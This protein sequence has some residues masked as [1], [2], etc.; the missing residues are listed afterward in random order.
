[1]RKEKFGAGDEIRTRDINLGKV[2][3]YQL[4]Y[5]RSAHK[6][7]GLTRSAGCQP[8][9]ASCDMRSILVFG[10]L[11]SQIFAQ[12]AR[13]DADFAVRVKE[14]TT[15]PEFLSPLVD[16]L[17]L[18]VGVPSPKDVLGYHVGTPKKLATSAQMLAY[19]RALEKSSP[20]VKILYVG[21]T[22]EGRDCWTVAIADEATIRRLDDYKAMLAKL[23]D[24][25][26][27]NPGELD[28]LLGDAKPIYHVTGGLHSS[29]T[30]P[31]DMLM[32][33]GYRI[34]AEDGALYDSIRKNLIVFLTPVLEPD[35]RDRYVAWYNQFKIHEENEDDRLPGPPYWGKYI[36]HDNNRDMHYSQIT[37]RNWLAAYLEWHPPIIHDLHESVPFL[38]TFSGQPPHNPNLDP[39]LYAELPWFANFEMTKMIGYGMPGV[40]THA[41][42]DMW[43]AGYLGFMSSNH[44]GM[45]RMYEVYGNGGA[46]TMKRKVDSADGTDRFGAS[47]RQWYRPLPAYKEVEWSFRNNINYGQTGVLT[48]LELAAGNARTILDNFYK[49]SLHSIEA[50]KNEAP[51]AFVI[52]DNQR[53]MTRVAWL[54]NTLRLQ[55]IEI[56]RSEAD[57]SFV[58]KRDQPYG[59]LAKSLLE[60]QV[61]PDPNLRTY[62]D[63]G[64]TMGLLSQVEVKAS[65]DKAILTAKTTPVDRFL[66]KG[67][68]TGAGTLLAVHHNGAH[69]LATLRYRLGKTVKV[70]ALE[71]AH[72]GIPAGSLLLEATARA[73]AL[74]EELGLR[75]TLLATR[76]TV[77]VH[78]VDLPRLAMYST[79]GNTQE[80]GW[81]RHAFDQVEI[82]FDLIFKD[83]V[84][85][86]SLRRDFDVILIPNQGRTAKGLVFDLESKGRPLPYQ[87]GYGE[88][89]DI[90]GGMG[91]EGALE[92]QKFVKE[93]GLLITL[94]G[95]SNFPVEYGI[96]GQV[97][98]VR[99]TA[100]FYAPG[101]IVEVDILQPKHP[102]F[103]GYATP[104]LAVRYANGP[105]LNVP[106]KDR[107]QQ[108]LMQF[109]GT[110]ASV[111]SGFMRGSS[112]IRN[113]PA[114]VSVPSGLG[115]VLMFA[116]NPCYRWQ[117]HGEFALLFNAI[118]H[119]NDW[120]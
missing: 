118:Q 43:S 7:Y 36:Y 114:L 14:W 67:Q 101:P 72:L 23:A 120:K 26:R 109:S 86:G 69:G 58:I 92:L 48:A 81:V 46:N 34:V 90:T 55:G 110:E 37:M 111:L 28:A 117:N 88:S 27:V 32:E 57:N 18:V 66:P 17:P 9:Y 80:V 99:P 119:F 87:G 83:R 12:P 79:W 102:I 93:G 100:Q 41:F 116:T 44:N 63:T 42:V 104:K 47:G 84:R 94:A 13:R 105:L 30:G 56:G 51:Y 3:L 106:E 61:Y 75:A 6:E 85:R 76:P 60:K 53:D 25:R 49:K 1:M 2:A 107:K 74:V 10:F 29:E 54:V 64:W 15:K 96:A 45:L 70:E 71:A 4:S 8:C 113:K 38:Y 68:I 115:R 33:L 24:P 16:H 20:R 65:N 21:K 82:P 89:T 35:G 108:V 52:P 59:R 62:D 5:S 98:A 97:D 73:R 50:G 19:F 78:E 40:W 77:A 31:P 39:I 112:E 22:D 91:L 103:Y 11:C 95:A